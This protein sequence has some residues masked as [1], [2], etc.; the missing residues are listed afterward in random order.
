MR[1]ALFDIKK[2]L[3]EKKYTTI[4]NLMKNAFNNENKDMHKDWIKE[5][6]KHYYDPMYQYKMEKR[7]KN[8]IFEG[9]KIEIE[10]YL[11]G[12]GIFKNS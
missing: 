5:I 3:P 9:L 7:K 11:K 12:L 1:K 10:S 2:R 8:I 4:Y 6:L